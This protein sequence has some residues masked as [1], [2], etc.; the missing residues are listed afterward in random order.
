VRTD[1][2][3]AY[4][5][6]GACIADVRCSH[7]YPRTPDEPYTRGA[8][9]LTPLAVI[10][11]YLD[12]AAVDPLDAEAFVAL[13]GLDADLAG[14]WLALIG[15]NAVPAELS[16]RLAQLPQTLFR[17]LA[18]S[19]ALAVLTVSGGARV[20]AQPWMNTLTASYLAE[21]LGES[22]ALGDGAARWRVLLALAGVNLPGDER[23]GDL[24]AFRGARV[25]LLEDAETLLRV[26]AVADV[27]D[28]LDPAPAQRVAA[29][30]LRIEP[31]EFQAALRTA[32]SRARQALLRLDL[33]LEQD[34]DRGERLWL[35]LR[36][37]LLG[38]L[39]T[40]VPTDR[41]GWPR[42]AEVH[43][44]V[45]RMLFAGH[46]TLFLVDQAVGRLCP[47]D[48]QGP[49]IALDSG[50]S[51]VARSARLGERIEF[52]DEFEA[53]VADRQLLRL[54]RAEAAVCLPVS[55]GPAQ[56]VLGV[57]LFPLQE[58]EC[59]DD[60]FAKALYARELARRL[61]AGQARVQGEQQ[62]LQRYRQREEQRLRELIHEANNPLSIVQN[63]LHILQL[64]LTTEPKAIDQLRLIAVELRRVSDLLEQV[65]QVPEVAEG[66]PER[67]AE[68]RDLDLNALIAELVEMHRGYA[69]GRGAEITAVLPAM[70]LRVKSDEQSIA[71]ILTNLM[72]NALEADRSHD[73]RVEALGGAFRDGRE[74]VLL[75]VSDTGPGLPREV[76]E[77]LGAPQ[78]TSKGGDHA[79]LGLH[80]V[81]RL[82]AELGGSIDVRTAPGY[83]TAFTV[84][85]PLSP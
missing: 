6:E 60:E 14:R 25:E 52:Y 21:V 80:I 38:R 84:F 53:A 3:G 48:G 61:A 79:G 27:F 20:G 72:R 5:Q 83:G 47:I 15:G 2:R 42:L 67:K 31:V 78:R 70:P 85:L 66:A 68:P 62:A 41:I 4:A 76:L 56:P 73:V 57:L 59:A 22:L 18:V 55:A 50:T 17:E 30:L 82:V 29:L 7:V 28:V 46:A 35:R 63:Y 51:L 81:H 11:R 75:V 26:F 13:L 44:S 19:Q 12:V 49:P 8:H 45:T 40:D 36:I 69:Q 71:Q 33:D 32:E 64:S 10:D 43:A 74:G 65:R 58:D 1:S 23:L 16:A 34:F 39:F 77:R 24:L 54:M 37:G 9:S